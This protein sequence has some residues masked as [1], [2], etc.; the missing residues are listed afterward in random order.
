MSRAG[1]IRLRGRR[2]R[3][4]P[5]SVVTLVKDSELRGRGGAGLSVRPQMDVPAEGPEGNAH[6][7][8]CRR[9]RAG[10]VQ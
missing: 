3:A 9:E 2:L 10:H 8:Q 1:A 4:D 7:H 6:V 5:D